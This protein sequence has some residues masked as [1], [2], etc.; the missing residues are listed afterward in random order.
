MRVKR[1]TTHT[2]R[3]RN[4]LSRVK[5]YQ[6]GRKN[7]LRQAKTAILKAGQHALQD[8]RKKKGTFRAL[9]NTRINAAVREHD[10]SYSQFMHALKTKDIQLDRKVLAELAKDRP[11]VFTKVVEAAK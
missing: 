11:E 3:R 7:L 1:G 10:M 4:I 9:W 8:R 5:G 2:K 6:Y